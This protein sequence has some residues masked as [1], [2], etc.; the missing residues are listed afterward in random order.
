MESVGRLPFGDTV[1]SREMR[2]DLHQVHAFALAA[3]RA[4]GWNIGVVGPW[5]DGQ[6]EVYVWIRPLRVVAW[7]E[8]VGVSACQ[9][10]RRF[11]W[12]GG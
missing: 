10:L 4:A 6:D 9:V 12:L 8:L 5:N 11:E 1:V 2:P 3:S 7:A